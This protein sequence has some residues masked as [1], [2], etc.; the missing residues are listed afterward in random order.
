MIVL[1]LE[2]EGDSVRHLVLLT[3]LSAA[4]TFGWIKMMSHDSMVVAFTIVCNQDMNIIFT[5]KFGKRR[6]G[7][8]F[9]DTHFWSIK[10]CLVCL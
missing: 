7:F 4:L 2:E 9:K 5:E 1:Q 10:D 6:S 8:L 3:M